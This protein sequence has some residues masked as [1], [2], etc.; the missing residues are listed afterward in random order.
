[1]VNHNKGIQMNEISYR[2]LA[3]SD[4]KQYHEVRFQCLREHP[5]SFG[6]TYEEEIRKKELK[7]DAY[8]KKLFEFGL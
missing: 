4:L 6:S 5:D 8:L 3:L 1:M 2:R 7:F